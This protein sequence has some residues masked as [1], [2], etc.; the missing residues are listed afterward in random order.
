MKLDLQRALFASRWPEFREFY[1]PIRISARGSFILFVASVM[2]SANTREKERA[3]ERREQKE[4]ETSEREFI[5]RDSSGN[6]SRFRKCARTHRSGSAGQR[7]Y[8]ET[9]ELTYVKIK[10]IISSRTSSCRWLLRRGVSASSQMVLRRHCLPSRQPCL[11][12]QH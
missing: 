4:T 12:S 3:R 6:K 11:K 1:I 8:A 2:S 7:A 5:T 9:S 10:W